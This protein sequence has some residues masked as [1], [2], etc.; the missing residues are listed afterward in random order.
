MG[1]KNT[2]KQLEAITNVFHGTRSIANVENRQR[3]A[4]SVGLPIPAGH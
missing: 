1:F 2:L 4:M 3:R